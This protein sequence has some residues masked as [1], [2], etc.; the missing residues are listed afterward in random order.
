VATESIVH[1]P[2]RI[3][4]AGLPVEPGLSKF[5]GWKSRN[6]HRERSFPTPMVVKIFLLSSTSNYIPAKTV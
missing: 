5:T 3:A 1:V 2:V 6:S 4:G